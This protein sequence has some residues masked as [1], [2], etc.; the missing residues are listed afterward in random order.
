VL[1]R[2]FGPKREEVIGGWRRLHNEEP[3]NF[4]ASPNV[5]SVVKSRRVRW[6]GHVARMGTMRN[7][8]KMLVGIPERRRPFGTPSLALDG[9]IIL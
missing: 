1:R 4:Y 5:I 6:V 8:Y 2:I 3:H 9:K 7:A